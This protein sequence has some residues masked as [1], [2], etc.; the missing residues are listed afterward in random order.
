MSSL[1]CLSSFDL[2]FNCI[3]QLN[4]KIQLSRTS[5]FVNCIKNYEFSLKSLQSRIR[6]IHHWVKW[7]FNNSNIAL[8][9]IHFFVI[10]CLI[11]IKFYSNPCWMPSNYCTSSHCPNIIFGMR[12]RILIGICNSNCYMA[13]IKHSHI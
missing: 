6:F 7:I 12:I 1:F 2:T 9:K 8:L 4:N 11:V 5:L 10:S 13:F 3:W